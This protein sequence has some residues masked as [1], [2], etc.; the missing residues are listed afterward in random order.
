VR[1]WVSDDDERNK[2]GFTDWTSAEVG[3]C[4]K[5]CKHA[6]VMNANDT[7][8]SVNIIKLIWVW[9]DDL[10]E[11]TEYSIKYLRDNVDFDLMAKKRVQF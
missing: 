10:Y 9:F 1:E 3:E 4:K 2:K 8:H 11:E 7:T 6:S 5:V